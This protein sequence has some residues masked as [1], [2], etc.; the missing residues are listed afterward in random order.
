MVQGKDGLT[1][2]YGRKTIGKTIGK[3]SP[4]SGSEKLGSGQKWSREAGEKKGRGV[5]MEGESHWR[6]S[7]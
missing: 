6:E 5:G 3:I 4:I 1:I 7:K 2:S